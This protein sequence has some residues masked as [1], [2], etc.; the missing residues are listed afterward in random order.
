MALAAHLLKSRSKR[1][2]TPELWGALGG[3]AHAVAS[4]EDLH[5]AVLGRLQLNVSLWSAAP[6]PAQRQLLSL[7]YKLA[8]VIDTTVAPCDLECLCRPIDLLN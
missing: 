1:H 8:K 3:L 6:V 7:L 4:A 5:T 2:L